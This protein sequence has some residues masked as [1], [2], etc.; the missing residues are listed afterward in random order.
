MANISTARK[1]SILARIASQRVERTRTFSAVLKGARAAG[2]HLGRILGQL[3]LEVTGFVFLA[4][5]LIG[6]GAFFREYGKL[7]AGHGGWSRPVIAILFTLMFG[8]FG[9]SS[10]WKVKKKRK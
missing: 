8:W 10:F 5:A 9:V 3:W 4:I 6:A 7:Q 1:L 2:T